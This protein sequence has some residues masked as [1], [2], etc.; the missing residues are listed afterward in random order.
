MELS[1]DE[2]GGGELA[3]VT[4]T[5]SCVFLNHNMKLSL[6]RALLKWCF[7]KVAT[8]HWRLLLRPQDFLREKNPNQSVHLCLMGGLS[9]RLSTPEKLCLG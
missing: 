7:R 3:P 2:M 5:W 6:N 8:L 1:G 9:C 4:I